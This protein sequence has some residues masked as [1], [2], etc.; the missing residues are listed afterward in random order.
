LVASI[1]PRRRSGRR[2]RDTTTTP[3]CRSP[4]A[5]LAVNAAHGFDWPRHRCQADSERSGSV[6]S[7]ERTRAAGGRAARAIARRRS[8]GGVGTYARAVVALTARVP[9]RLASTRGKECAVIL[10]ASPHLFVPHCSTPRQMKLANALCRYRE[11]AVDAGA[12][13]RASAKVLIS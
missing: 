9:A 10:V 8:H 11:L 4:T 3:V 12:A 2:S 5:R 6:E 7:S 1:S 13:L